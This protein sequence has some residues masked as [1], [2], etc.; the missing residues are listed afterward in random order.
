MRRIALLAGLALAACGQQQPAARKISVPADFALHSALIALPADPSALPAAADILTQ[1]CTG[2][3][4]A[5]MITAQPP[6]DA[7]KWQ[8]EI[9][10]MRGV[11]KAPID[12]GDDPKLIAAL[13]AL[14]TQT[15]R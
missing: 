9:D 4:S 1:N 8:A 12:A 10:K 2:C 15:P 14:E 6:L 5:E 3:H 13:L 7:K 11:F